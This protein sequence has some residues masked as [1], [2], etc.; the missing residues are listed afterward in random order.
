MLLGSLK[1]AEV[2][3]PYGDSGMVQGALWSS[4]F[5]GFHTE[6]MND[7][8]CRL[9]TYEPGFCDPVCQEGL[10]LG[11][12]CQDYP[13]T[14]AGVLTV[15]GLGEELLVEPQPYPFGGHGYWTVTER[16]ELFAGGDQIGVSAPG[17]D[18]PG[19][20]VTAG[21]VDDLELGLE[22]DEIQMPN[23]RDHTFTWPPSPEREE[24]VR[25]TLNANNEFHGAPYLAIIE[26]DAP[27]ADGA[28]TIPREMV[29]AFP[30]TE[31]WDACAGSD[32][33]LSHAMLYRRGV[34]GA[35]DGEVELLVGS[36]VLFYLVHPAADGT[37]SLR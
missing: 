5:A 37:T 36:E 12:V 34:A 27:A 10:C 33:P 17:G 31:H 8:T 22:N 24:R 9:L 13:V 29:E 28:I 26:C 11:G 14:D 3:A 21:G 25:L 32:C 6:V 18:F 35:G 23:G 7:G 2:H 20:E 16:S 1:V 19:F 15:S 4:A 30:P